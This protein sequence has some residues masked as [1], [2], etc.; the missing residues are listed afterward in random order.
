MLP[1]ARAE[2]TRSDD[3][4]AGRWESRGSADL[5]LI[6]RIDQPAPAQARLAGQQ[7]D[8]AEAS[9]QWW[10]A[11]ER[12]QWGV[13]LAGVS[14][15]S[16]PL[17][18]TRVSAV[19]PGADGQALLLGSGAMMTLGLRVRATEQSTLYADAANVSGFGLAG[20][21]R[22]VGKVGVQFQAARSRWDV[23]YGGLGLRLAG[24]S[25]MTVKLRKGGL[26]IFMKSSF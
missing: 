10:S 22:L 6:T 18:G 14:Y 11:T 15:G 26:G 23:A 20:S 19:A 2:A 17:V 21:E 9:R 13:G 12:A 25:R 24:D 1:P 16:R 8:V 3:D 7:V 4:G 5:P